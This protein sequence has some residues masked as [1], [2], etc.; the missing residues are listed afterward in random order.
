MCFW[1]RSLCTLVVCDAIQISNDGEEKTVEGEQ[2][3]EDEEDM[4][5]SKTFA[6]ENLGGMESTEKHCHTTTV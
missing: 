1:K 2:E 4:M 3:E 5:K 6:N